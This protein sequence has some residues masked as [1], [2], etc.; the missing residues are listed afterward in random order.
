MGS[1]TLGNVLM[2]L[3]HI[4]HTAS[5]VVIA[6]PTSVSFSPDIGV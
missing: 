6:I 1:I 5:V 3:G 2:T 4:H